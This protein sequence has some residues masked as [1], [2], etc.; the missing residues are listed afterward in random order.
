MP[1]GD[2]TV[3]PIDHDHS[4]LRLRGDSLDWMTI[5]ILWFGVGFRVDEPEELVDHL[6][7]TSLRLIAALPAAT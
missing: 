4:L 5:S 6:R 2:A 1:P 7:A 3:E